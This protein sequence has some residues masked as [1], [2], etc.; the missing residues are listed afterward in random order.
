MA[1][2]STNKL[3][4]LKEI[5][6]MAVFHSQDQEC[7]LLCHDLLNSYEELNG[8]TGIQRNRLLARM[9]AIIAQL[10]IH[11]CRPCLPE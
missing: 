1:N 3:P 2:N 5:E 6:E 7:T 9:K 11:K 10:R 4:S 8:V